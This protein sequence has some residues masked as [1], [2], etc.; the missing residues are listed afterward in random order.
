MVQRKKNFVTKEELMEERTPQKLV[1][2]FDRKIQEITQ[3]EDGKNAIRMREGY[4]KELMEEIYP[5]KVFA[6]WQF[7]DRTDVTLKP[8]IGNQNY[9]ALIIDHAFDPPHES[10]LEITMALGN[11]EY[12]LKRLMLQK[13]GWAPISGYIEKTGTKN[14]GRNLTPHP[15]VRRL[16]DYLENQKNL[17]GK[18]LEKKLQ[19]EYETNTSLLIIFEDATTFD[20]TKIKEELCC[21]VESKLGAEKTQ[22]LHLYLIGSSERINYKWTPNH[23]H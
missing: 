21:F 10:K 17:I 16:E 12:F 19:K 23:T 4:C 14:K 22:F 8:V 11:D 7:G 3:Q 15:G 5:L 1:E 13:E 6:S 9:D 20:E 2:W 18:A